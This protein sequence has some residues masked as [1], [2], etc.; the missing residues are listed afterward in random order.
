M[1]G[2]TKQDIEGTVLSYDGRVYTFLLPKQETAVLKFSTVH[3]QCDFPSHLMEDGHLKVGSSI[4]MCIIDKAKKHSVL[5][6]HRYYFYSRFKQ[7]SDGS[8]VRQ[9]NNVALKETARAIR[10]CAGLFEEGLT[11]VAIL[12][13]R[14]LLSEIDKDTE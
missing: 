11:D 6:D 8:I 9:K 2:Y 10:Q 7:L 3:D 1:G 14:A 5:P 13:L 4:H 12:S